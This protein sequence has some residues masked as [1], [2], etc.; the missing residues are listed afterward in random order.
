MYSVYVLKS[1]RNGKKYVGYTQKLPEQRLSEHNSGSNAWTRQN[2][3]FD[4]VYN[5]SLKSRHEAVKRETYLKS[6]AGRL[7]VKRILGP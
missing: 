3:P 1:K 5:E 6:T 7:F 4:L 2:G